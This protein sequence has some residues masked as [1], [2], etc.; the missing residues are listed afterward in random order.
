MKLPKNEM[1]LPKNYPIPPWGIY[2]SSEEKQTNR[3]GR[4]ESLGQFAISHHP[5]IGI[6]GKEYLC[7]HLNQP[8]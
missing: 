1:K 6:C 2:N 4:R 7:L 3:K 5:E 8:F